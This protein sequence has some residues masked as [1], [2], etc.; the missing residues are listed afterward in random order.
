MK[1]EVCLSDG[2][3]DRIEMKT[4]ESEEATINKTAEKLLCQLK[5]FGFVFYEK[6][7]AFRAI[8]ANAIDEVRIVPDGK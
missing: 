6:G 2:S 3:V 7:G 1:F 4:S 5:E 8:N